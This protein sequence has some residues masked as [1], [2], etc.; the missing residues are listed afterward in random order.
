MDRSDTARQRLG[1]RVLVVAL[2]VILGATVYGDNRGFDRSGVASPVSGALR[3]GEDLGRTASGISRIAG[4]AVTLGVLYGTVLSR[5]D[6]GVRRSI[7]AAVDEIR[8]VCTGRPVAPLV[9]RCT[10]KKVPAKKAVRCARA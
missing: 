9:S 7:L 1:R 5:M 6:P 4:E 3:L 2:A 8:E 10:A